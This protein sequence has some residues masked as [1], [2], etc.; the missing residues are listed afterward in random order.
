MLEDILNQNYWL[1]ELKDV[2]LFTKIYVGI[3]KE[4]NY[5]TLKIDFTEQLLSFLDENDYTSLE[6][7]V[8]ILTIYFSRTNNTEGSIFNYKNKTLYKINYNKDKSILKHLE[9]TKKDIDKLNSKSSDNLKN[10]IKNLYPDIVDSIYA[11]SINDYNSIIN[12]K[13]NHNFLHVDFDTNFLADEEIDSL[14]NNIK[15]LISNCVKNCEVEC[16]KVGIIS[17]KEIKRI[18]EYSQ[19]PQVQFEDIN[20]PDIIKNNS[21]KYPD[22]IAI[23]DEINHITYKQL[24]E[25]IDSGA[26]ILQ[27]KYD[28]KK[29][30]RILLYMS[31]SYN[32]PVLCISLMKLGAIVI[33]VDDIF[34][35]GYVNDIISDFHPKYIICEQ[36]LELDNINVIILDEFNMKHEDLSFKE[37]NVDLDDTALIMCTSGTTGKPKGVELTQKNII[38]ISH[39]CIDYFNFTPNSGYFMCLTEFTCVSSLLIYTMLM[40]GSEVFIIRDTNESISK[41]AQYLMTSHCSILVSSPNVGLYLYNNFDINVDY[42]A[43]TGS[44]LTYSK[45]RNYNRTQ[46]FNCYGCTEISGASIFNKLKSDYSNYS[47][48]GRPALNCSAYIL[49]DNHKMV[50]LGCV[51]EIA[52]AGPFVS[53]QYFNNPLK[54]KQ[55]YGI[56]NGKKVYFTNDL[57]Y[58]NQKGEIVYV[59]RCDNQINLNGFKIEPEGIENIIR[60]YGDITQVKVINNQNYLV[61]YYA[62]KKEID[63]DNLDEYLRNKL[64]QYMIPSFYVC[65]EELPVNFNGKIDVKKLP[66]V[67]FEKDEFELRI[68]NCF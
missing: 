3:K 54:T 14:Y 63:E 57:G 18:N 33:P 45:I 4:K 1:N 31:R 24:D 21:K 6:F 9:D 43:L 48:I 19:G 20:L 50:P 5:K 67:E 7:I 39:L 30:D 26:T 36:D 10:R 27:N 37:V 32:V 51:G 41:I 13:I 25:L 15:T 38:S 22:K 8:A 35:L 58:F 61:A 12:F 17:D 23:N 11:Y 16:G 53:K 56:V 66:N 28:I 59:G 46:L 64:P 40:V 47:V 68:F 2:S 65:M 60:K 52:I 34:P 44:K 49:D 62:A 42:L 29:G 55:S